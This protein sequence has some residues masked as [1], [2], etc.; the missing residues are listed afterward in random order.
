MLG[1]EMAL[2]KSDSGQDGVDW[3]A[4]LAELESLD[5]QPSEADLRAAM[6]D[7]VAVFRQGRL[8]EAEL[9]WVLS[10]LAGQ[11]I[12]RKFERILLNFGRASTRSPRFASRRFNGRGDGDRRPAR[13]PLRDGRLSRV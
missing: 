7:T 3:A 11:L 6:R 12:N 2:R 10:L 8:T 4:A 5:W 13:P 1:A 9:K